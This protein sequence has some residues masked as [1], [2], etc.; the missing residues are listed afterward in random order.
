[1]SVISIQQ[2][3]PWW[4]PLATNLLIPMIGN[5][6]ESQRQRDENRKRNAA[7]GEVL[8]QLG[9]LQGMA[10]AQQGGLLQGLPEPEGYNSNGWAQAYHKNDNP[11]GQFD[12]NTTSLLPPTT[13]TQPRTPTPAEIQRAI[14]ETLT[15]K[16]FGMLDPKA[17]QEDFAPYLT[18]N[19]AARQEGFRNEAMDD[20]RNAST[21]LDQRNA[22]MSHVIRGTL[23]ES[24]GNMMQGQYIADRAQFTPINTGGEYV[25][26]SVDSTTG[27]YNEQS[28]MPMTLTPRQ[29]QAGQQWQQN[30]GETQRRW[31]IKR[32]DRRTDA[33]RNYQIKRR[34]QP[35]ITRLED[36]RRIATY[37]D[38]TEKE[39][40]PDTAGFNSVE[41]ARL[42]QLETQKQGLIAQQTE[43]QKALAQAQQAGNA[44]EVQSLT[45]SLNNVSSALKQIDG[46]INGMYENKLNPPRNT[47][48]P[49]TDL[50]TPYD[51]NDP[52]AYDIGA[53]M[54][55]NAH[56]GPKGIS[57]SYKTIRTKKD[58][59][60][61]TH[62]GVDYLTPNGT[63]ILVPDV[64]TPLTVTRVRNQPD[65]Y[66]H[67]AR[68][69]GKVNG[70]R[71]E[72][73]V[74]HMQPG[75]NVKEGDVVNAGDLIGLSGNSGNS[76][77]KNGGYHMHLECK[78]DGEYVDPT[79]AR[80]IIAGW[81]PEAAKG[82]ERP[83]FIGPDVNG[84]QRVITLGEF[85]ELVR[86][87]EAGQLTGA[88]NVRT[89]EDVRKW[90]EGKG[91][92]QSG[93]GSASQTSA[94]QAQNGQQD[95]RGQTTSANPSPTVTGMIFGRDMTDIGEH[96]ANGGSMKDITV[97]PPELS[98][99][100][101]T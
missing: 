29:V 18:A 52:S 63:E 94:T 57:T 5:A 31:D 75:V 89:A 23:P 20:Y 36:G 88:P 24:T 54:T 14:A 26:G 69:S 3:K 16:R 30:F 4:M 83:A 13:Q 51:N 8:R 27:R 56:G 93:A 58:G 59:S 55:G 25:L 10:N 21:P 47:A 99:G 66:G 39:L 80:K 40:T 7:K 38:G 41:K 53:H 73:T 12:A 64:G 82:E 33:D 1:M 61:Y 35:T 48:Q 76:R 79:Q 86:R 37:P 92:K 15:T 71:V 2:E 60:T 11:L 84:N 17:V 68:L 91:Y 87:A 49:S 96:L 62:Y 85:N 101:L 70:H 6:I 72:F 90:L 100:L 74:A 34:G 9:Q 22:V 19:E 67:Y 65:G 28:R 43:L 32:N 44:A 81:K 45:A 78:I 77:G 95:Q 46:E 97:K 50:W 98:G 42:A